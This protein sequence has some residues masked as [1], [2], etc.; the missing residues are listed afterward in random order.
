[1]RKREKN[2]V[3]FISRHAIPLH[4]PPLHI[5][6]ETKEHQKLLF[7]LHNTPLFS[8]AITRE[9]LHEAQ[10]NNTNLTWLR[11]FIALNQ[12]P[13]NDLTLQEYYRLF[14]EL[15][16][17]NSV[18]HKGNQILLPKILQQEAICLAHEGSYPGQDAIKRCLRAH[19]WF[20][21]MDNAI[22]LQ[23]ENYHECQIT[24]A[25]PIISGT[26]AQRLEC[27]PMARETWVQSQ[28]ESYQRL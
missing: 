11:H 22:K 7:L 18:I 24:T 15:S 9:H 10:L 16:I 8:T 26:L 23:V 5:A 20:P 3:D 27:S 21:R 2:P 17:E 6:E 19:F 25:T 13:R 14:S 12:P 4:K 28:V 1:M